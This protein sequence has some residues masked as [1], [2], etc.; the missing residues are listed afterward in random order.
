MA[1]PVFTFQGNVNDLASAAASGS[2]LITANCGKIINVSGAVLMAGSLPVKYD[3]TG[4]FSVD[5]PALDAD[6]LPT[7]FGFRVE[8]RVGSVRLPLISFDAVAA[9]ETVDLVDVVD[10][11]A[12]APSAT[13]D[14]AIAA[15]VADDTTPSATRA[16]LDA[17][18]GATLKLRAMLGN[19][20]VGRW[21]EPHLRR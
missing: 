15:L 2:L 7:L 18:Y 13:V 12:S 19:L 16:A 1:T 3:D 6:N 14:T 20:S 17:A 8:G 10:T 21:T 4:S 11:V 5:L 9:G